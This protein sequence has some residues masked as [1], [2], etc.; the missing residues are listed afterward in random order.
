MSDKNNLKRILVS[1]PSE[2]FARLCEIKQRTG[3]Q[4][5]TLIRIMVTYSLSVG[6]EKALSE[7]IKK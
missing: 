4:I 6:F 1:F 7:V 2:D 5:T 3:I